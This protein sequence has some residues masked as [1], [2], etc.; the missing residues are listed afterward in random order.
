MSSGTSSRRIRTGT[1]CGKRI[2]SNVGSIWGTRFDDAL[3]IGDVRGIDRVA[4]A[5][6]DALQLGV[7]V[8]HQGD[9]GAI[10]PLDVFQLGL[11]EIAIHPEGTAVDE[12]RDGGAGRT[13]LPLIDIQVGGE[14]VKRR[15]DR[16]PAQVE[17]CLLELDRGFADA[18]VGVAG[19]AE[20]GSCLV[21]I[22]L[23]GSQCGLGLA[24]GGPRTVNCRLELQDRRRLLLRV[25]H[26]A[27]LITEET[28][29]ARGFRPGV[30]QGRLPLFDHGP[31]G[32]HAGFALQDPG[33]GRLDRGFQ[34]SDVFP[35]LLQLDLRRISSQLIRTGIDPE[36]QF[37]LADELIVLHRDL[38]DVARHPRCDLDDVRPHL[39]V[40]CP[41][42]VCPAL[43]DDIR[44]HDGHQDQQ[45]RWQF[46]A[47]VL[48]D[49]GGGCH[50]HGSG[51]DDE[52]SNECCCQQ[53]QRG[54][55]QRRMPEEAAEAC[56]VEQL[57]D[58]HRAQQS[59]HDR[60]EQRRKVNAQD[61]D[62]GWDTGEHGYSLPSRP[63]PGPVS[64]CGAR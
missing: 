5:V 53:P 27:R 22:G 50:C 4:D 29:R 20:V 24:E 14:S 34:R 60:H 36:E 13:E 46:R 63:R 12:R 33:F 3:G 37:A 47:N 32:N 62:L 41:R 57:R 40:P 51:R 58:N 38:D 10:A 17:L 39:A 7:R 2:Q 6:D 28:P 31:R 1:R 42:V 21:E 44:E 15:V 23:R 26:R 35:G 9:D 52:Q 43:V 19:L 64:A 16:G 49:V 30:R 55:G 8:A 61:L 25:L 54:V 59:G 11:L 56:P 18:H 48:H 45:Q